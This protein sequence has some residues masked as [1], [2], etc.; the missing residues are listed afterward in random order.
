MTG[1]EIV[2]AATYGVPAVRV[3]LSN[4]RLA[5]IYDMQNPM[6]QGRLCSGAYLSPV[7]RA[8]RSQARTRRGGVPYEAER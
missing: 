4:S 8:C 3:I 7:M 1:K 2:A 5:M 6:Y